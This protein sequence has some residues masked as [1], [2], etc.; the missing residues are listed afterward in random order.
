[1][2]K[3]NYIEK[4]FEG[5]LTNKE[6]IDFNKLLEEDHELASAFTYE[7]NVKQ[8]ITLNERAALKRQLQS[9]ETPKKPQRQWMYVAAS[10][11][12]LLGLFSWALFFNNSCDSLYDEYYQTYPNTVS[13]TVRGENNLGIKSEAFYAYDSG[14]YQKSSQLFAKIYSSDGDDYALF[15]RGLSLMELQKFDEAL[16]VLNQYDYTKN[17]AFAPFFRWYAALAYLKLGQ[18]EEAIK[19]LEILTKTDNPQKEAAVR[20]LSE[21][22]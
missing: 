1:M 11:V 9:Y 5:T 19:S 16:V 17:N 7:K 15:Y 14:D 4:Y 13:P 6:E 21:L 10:V 20:L 18:K 12:A 8:A 22:K 2:D 3:Y